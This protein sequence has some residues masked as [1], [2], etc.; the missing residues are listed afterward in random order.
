M[1]TKKCK[2]VTEAK[3]YKPTEKEETV[4]RKFCERRDAEM[5]T[6]VKISRADSA[7]NISV[8]HPDK[9]IGYALLA[10]AL[11]T[12][13]IDFIDGLVFQLAESGSRGM[14]TKTRS[15]SCLP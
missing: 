15:I 7:V 1:K 5:A 14:S 6:R 12:S 2:S 13:N 9:T 10:E 11:G 4:L 8:D 3:P